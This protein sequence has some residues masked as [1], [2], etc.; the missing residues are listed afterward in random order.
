M[1][2]IRLEG[3]CNNNNITMEK[4]K[5][6]SRKLGGKKKK[7]KIER[8]TKGVTHVTMREGCANSLWLFYTFIHTIAS[9]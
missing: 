5:K 9:K 4:K 8:K 6:N 3:L 1:K 2:K 7:G